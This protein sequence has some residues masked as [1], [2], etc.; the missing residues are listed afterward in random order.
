MAASTVWQVTGKLKGNYDN[1]WQSY[2]LTN[3][4]VTAMPISVPV[5]LLFDA[6]TPESFFVDKPL[7]YTATAGKSGIGR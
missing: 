5:L 6:A 3:A 7:S 4:T 1:G 2:D